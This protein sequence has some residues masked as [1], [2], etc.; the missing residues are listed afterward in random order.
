MAS[1][2]DTEAFALLGVG[3]FVVAI[4]TVSRVST[5]GFKGLWAEYVYP[6]F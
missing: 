1:A 4:R 5:A 6:N 2:F 3:V